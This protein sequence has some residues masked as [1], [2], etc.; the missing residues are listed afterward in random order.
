MKK[1]KVVILG[2]GLSGLACA[3]EILHKG[4]G[5]FEVVVLEKQPFIGGLAAT[6]KKDGFLFDLAPHRWFT[7]NEELN[8]WIDQLMGKE[9]IW[10]E[11]YTPI[12]QHGKFFKYPIELAD[13]LKKVDPFN[14]AAIM[15]TYLWARVSNR[16]LK[17]KIVTLKDAYISHFGY[18]LYKW[19]NEEHNEKLWGKGG[20]EVMSSDFFAQRYRN[21]SLIEGIKNA[22]GFGK[23]VVSLTPKFRFPKLGIGRISENL[24]LRIKK[25]GGVIKNNVSIR[26]IVK[27]KTGYRISTNQGDFL[28]DYLVSSIPVDELV[29]L[30]EPKAPPNI[31][32]DVNRLNYVHQKIVILLANKPRLTNFTWVYVHPP[33]IKFF[34]FLETNNWSPAMS[35]KGKTSL[36]FEYPYQN[37]DD[38]EKMSEKNLVKLTISDFIKYFSPQTKRADIIRGYVFEARKAYPKYD[39]QYHQSLGKIKDYL[40]QNFP[41]LQLIGRNGMFRYNNMDHAVYTGQLAGRNII[42]GKMIYNIENVNE[43]AE[44][45]EE[46]QI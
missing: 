34:R 9:M 31:L 35:P 1:K 29:K 38:L 28:A 22:L 44:Y 10:V 4:N 20:C 18:I 40:K 32:Q 46:K 8:Q 41:N 12:Y 3:D 43:E 24:S 13:V 25:N 6:F 17:K 16:I 30:M 7:K 23:T 5:E 11:K 21:L 19:F 14:I 15:L 39:L 42:A 45:L 2:A 27:T 37:G 36:V 33:K 26:E